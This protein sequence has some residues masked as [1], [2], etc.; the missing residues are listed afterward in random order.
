[1][2]KN[3]LKIALRNLRRNRGYAVLNM[4]GLAIG[5]ACAL[6]IL[7]FVQDELSYDKFHSN[8]DRIQRMV[9]ERIYPERIS[10]YA[11]IP[12]SFGPV[13]VS[14]LPEVV[15]QVRIVNF[16]QNSLFKVDGEVR[17]ESGLMMCDSTFFEVFGFELKQGDPTRALNGQGS[18]VITERAA[19]RLFGSTDVMGKTMEFNQGAWQ[20]VT[21]TGVVEDPPSQS[22]LTFDFL[23]PINGL[24]F[25]RNNENFISFSALTYLLLTPEADP[26]VVED[27]LLQLVENYAAGQIQRNLGMS[28]EDYIAEG[29]GYHYYL[30]PISSIHLNS[31]LEAEVKPNGNRTYVYLFIAIASFILLIA[32]IN[33]MN[34][35]TARSAERA[36]EVGVRKVLGSLPS[37][38]VTQFLME[39][40]ILTAVSFLLALVIMSL[41]RPIFEELSGKM[42][43]F[44]W[45]FTPWIWPLLLLGIIGVGLLA[46]SYPALVLSRFRPVEVLKGSF[47][48]TRQGKLLRNGLVVFQ[49]WISIA[50][51]AAT[52]VVYQQMEFTRNKDLGYN[53]ERLVVVKRVGQLQEKQDAFRN[54]VL[55][56]PQVSQVSYANDVPGGFYF[57]AMFQQD[58]G[59]NEVVTILGTNIDEY[60]LETMD[61][62]L[63][64]GRN[65]E[66]G[67]NDS[68]SIILNQTAVETFGLEDPIGKEVFFQ[69]LQGEPIPYRVIG[70]VEDYHFQSLHTKV[71]GLALFHNDAAGVG[72]GVMAVR[73]KEKEAAATMDRLEETW[74]QFSPE[75]PFTFRYFDEQW[76]ELYAAEQSSGKLFGA[77]AVLAILIACL[78]LFGLSAY[79][80]QQRTKEIGIRK[81]LGASVSQL[82]YLLSREITMLVWLALGLAIPTIWY[83][84][85]QW[86]GGFEYHVSLS[87]WVFAL[88]GLAATLIA[89]GTVSFQS[90]KT[91]L[92]SPIK[93]LR[94]E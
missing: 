43:D 13:A 19:M 94:D 90:F 69:N 60:F 76:A 87:P 68:T 30:Q 23:M 88:A 55:R 66:L 33:F 37:Q 62:E 6:L 46:G 18:L 74:R 26:K 79:T 59:D 17:E 29:N 67:F 24:P 71:S 42:V 3:S 92:M 34:L 89:W 65:F 39:A 80:A 32:V 77:F 20:A 15:N 93:S 4:L 61:I 49:F 57:G 50:L 14:D 11:V 72:I 25:I 70:V 36:R 52:V 10:E 51:M 48:S 81:I 2:F 21:V 44:S 38:L 47:R 22:H 7:V 5:L 84:M 75:I 82:M 12:H 31:N 56:D 1:M 28:Y 78:G 16:G 8:G 41:I 9:L 54:E 45:L 35:A 40:V 64:A 86:L 91:A 85:S 63:L 83:L 27:K 58:G 73:M 53:P